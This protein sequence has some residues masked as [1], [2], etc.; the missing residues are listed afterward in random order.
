MCPWAGEFSSLAYTVLVMGQAVCLAIPA[1]YRLA[2]SIC[3]GSPRKPKL[4][5]LLILY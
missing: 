5:M 3:S 1:Q 4:S 2:V